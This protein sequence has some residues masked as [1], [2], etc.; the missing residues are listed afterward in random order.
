MAFVHQ[1]Q[2]VALEGVDGDGLVAHLVLELVDI[3]DLNRPPREQ[4]ARPC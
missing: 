4:S 1:H 3:E 2:V